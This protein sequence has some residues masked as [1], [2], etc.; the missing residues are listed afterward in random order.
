QVTVGEGGKVVYNPNNIKAA[1]GDI[2]N[3]QFLGGAHSVSQSGGVNAPC[4]QLEGGFDSDFAPAANGEQVWEL[5]IDDDTKPI[6]FYCKQGLH[7]QQGM[8]GVINA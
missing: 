7:C 2:I 6:W 1:K 5:T 4:A 8:A 3:F